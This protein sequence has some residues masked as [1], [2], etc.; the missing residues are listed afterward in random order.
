[1]K[2]F[3]PDLESNEAAVKLLVE[4]IDRTGFTP[5]KTSP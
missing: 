1:M 3:V 5:G 4:A 2:G